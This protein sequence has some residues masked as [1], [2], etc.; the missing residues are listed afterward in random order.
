MRS[1]CSVL[2]FE[3]KLYF[4]TY[5]AVKI[6]SVFL[7]FKKNIYSITIDCDLLDTCKVTVIKR[8]ISQQIF[9]VHN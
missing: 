9:F 8:T 5:Q 2:F 6:E 3:I 4:K 7:Q 1:E